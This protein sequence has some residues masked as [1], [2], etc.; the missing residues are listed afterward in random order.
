[1]AKKKINKIQMVNVKGQ[2][3]E[4]AFNYKVIYFVNEDTS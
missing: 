1:M 2:K 4:L 3:N